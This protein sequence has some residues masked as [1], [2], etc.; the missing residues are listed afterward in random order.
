MRKGGEGTFAK[1]LFPSIS[2]LWHRT[3]IL[4]KLRFESLGQ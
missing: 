2:L 4:D 3:F 1:S